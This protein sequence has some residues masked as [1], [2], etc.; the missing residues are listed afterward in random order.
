MNAIGRNGRRGGQALTDALLSRVCEKL[1]SK[2]ASECWSVL[3][4]PTLR[5]LGLLDIMRLEYIGKAVGW[6]LVFSS[7]DNGC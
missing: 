3:K 6:C 2:L 4:K 1:N 5:L 7:F